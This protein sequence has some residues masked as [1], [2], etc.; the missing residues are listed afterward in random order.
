M[1]PTFGSLG[2]CDECGRQEI[3]DQDGLCLLS[4]N[5]EEVTVVQ[6]LKD[7]NR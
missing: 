5:L 7:P 1:N 6:D 3:P 2:S 4:E